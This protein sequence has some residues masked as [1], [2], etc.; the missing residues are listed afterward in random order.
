L[1][2]KFEIDHAIDNMYV[3]KCVFEGTIGSLFNI[4]SKTKDGLSA[5]KDLQALE[6]RE[7]VHPQETLNRKAY[8][9]P[10]SYTLT[11]EK[12]EICKCLHGIRVPKG[13]S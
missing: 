9:P 10:V 12:R 11:I 5:C 1:E 13:F 6:I 3:E 8:L 7:E 4:P 2:K